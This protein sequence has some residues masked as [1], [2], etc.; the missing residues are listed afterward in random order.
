MLNGK[1]VLLDVDGTIITDPPYNKDCSIGTDYF[2]EILRDALIEKLQINALEAIDIIRKH[3]F[4]FNGCMFATA[5]SLGVDA[6]AY[7]R[8]VTAWQEKHISP[9]DDSVVLVKHLYSRGIRIYI[10]SN[11]SCRG[12]LAK[13]ARA[14]LGNRHGS[15][16]FSRIYGMDTF[17][18]GYNKSM[19]EVYRRI[20]ETENLDP[21]EVLTIGDNPEEDWKVPATT[22]IKNSI[23]IQRRRP[24]K[25]TPYG[26]HVYFVNDLKYISEILE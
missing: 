1:Y 25:I 23:I 22:G 16:Y 11:N 2:R 26:Q 21:A 20:L 15:E 3:E 14:G 9:Y 13:L 8:G 4:H 6:E 19:A 5:A 24:E 10:V 7:W 17:G 18:M 12:I